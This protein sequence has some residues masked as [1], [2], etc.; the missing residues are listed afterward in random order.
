[1]ELQHRVKRFGNRLI[2]GAG[3]MLIAVFIAVI[4]AVIFARQPSVDITSDAP[5]FVPTIAIAAGSAIV[6]AAIG[7]FITFWSNILPVSMQRE[8]ALSRSRRWGWLWWLGV[9]VAGVLMTA[10]HWGI[11]ATQISTGY[12][13]ALGAMML[14]GTFFYWGIAAAISLVTNAKRWGKDR[15]GTIGTEEMQPRDERERAI[16]ERASRYM[17]DLGLL[18]FL[19]LAF[20]IAQGEVTGAAATDAILTVL[21]LQLTFRNFIAWRLGLK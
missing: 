7:S 6:I 14:R 17:F 11:G 3:L 9:S 5:W 2:M 13:Y 18:L 16:Y 19:V 20:T 15:T 10:Y 4:A 1:M 21:A 12:W 8:I